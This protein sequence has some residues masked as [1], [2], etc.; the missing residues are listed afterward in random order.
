MYQVTLKYDKCTVTKTSS[1]FEEAYM[2]AWLDLWSTV[3]A[4]Y[5]CDD[6]HAAMKHCRENT[7]KY[8]KII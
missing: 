2:E 1:N 7:I 4:Y 3:L 5:V 8:C 6:A